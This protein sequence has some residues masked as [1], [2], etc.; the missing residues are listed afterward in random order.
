MFL[1]LILFPQ[2]NTVVEYECEARKGAGDTP[3]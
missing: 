1:K 2:D 3:F